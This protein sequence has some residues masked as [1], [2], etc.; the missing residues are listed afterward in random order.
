MGAVVKATPHHRNRKPV[1]AKRETT[2]TVAKRMF[3][4]YVSLLGRAR[5]VTWSDA[6]EEVRD[7]WM[8]KARMMKADQ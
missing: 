8:Q 1:F 3:H 7:F 2:G 4:E 6:S 5:P